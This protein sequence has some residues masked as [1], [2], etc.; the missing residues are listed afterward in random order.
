MLVS[1]KETYICVVHEIVDR[2]E[3]SCIWTRIAT[4]GTAKGCSRLGRCIRDGNVTN[5]NGISV[6][7]G[8]SASKCVRKAEPVTD[9]MYS[10]ITLFVGSL[11]VRLG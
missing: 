11:G 8:A 1:L 10:G 2:V 4:D 7:T 3:S 6:V 5:G 9:L